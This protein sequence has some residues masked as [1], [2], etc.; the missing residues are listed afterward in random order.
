MSVAVPVAWEAQE[1]QGLLISCPIEDVLF[2]GA[3]GGGK[4][5]GILGDWISHQHAYGKHA[6]GIIFR[7]TMDE[8]DEVI[9]R[10]MEIFPAVGGK[11][12]A[13]KRT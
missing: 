5:D 2:G 11:W 8:L 1:R 13:S 10:S 9:A 4:T 3:R 12:R 6:K 7:R